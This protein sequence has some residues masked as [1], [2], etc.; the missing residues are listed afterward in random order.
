MNIIDALLKTMAIVFLLV[1]TLFLFSF[2][3]EYVKMLW[4]KHK[5]RKLM[6]SKPSFELSEEAQKK[7]SKILDKE[8]K[9]NEENE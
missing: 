1:F 5:L 7:I 4:M 2:L 3:V 9:K 6:S 8:I